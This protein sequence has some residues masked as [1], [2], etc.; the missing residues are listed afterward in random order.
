MHLSSHPHW[1]TC[2]RAKGAI[3][4][5]RSTDLLELLFIVLGS[6]L[7]SL[8]IFL[9]QRLHWEFLLIILEKSPK[10]EVILGVQVRFYCHIILDQ[11]QE[12]LLQ[13]VDFFSDE[14]WVDK[15]EIG[16]G[17]VAVI[18]YL[19]GYEQ[20]TQKKWSPVGGL[21][22][23]LCESDQPVDI[24]EAYDAALWTKL[25]TVVQSLDEFENVL[26]SWSFPQ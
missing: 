21:Q 26:N 16:V 1:F 14:K 20:R 17:E 7:Q 15:R 11:L 8:C 18:P 22:R 12:L 2:K 6:K 24:Y 25:S 13:L 19:L 23:H 3:E 10:L 5:L 4:S 9:I